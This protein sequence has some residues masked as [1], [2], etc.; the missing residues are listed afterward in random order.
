MTH[1]FSDSTIKSL[2]GESIGDYRKLLKPYHPDWA[3]AKANKVVVIEYENSSRGL[4]NHVAKYLKLASEQPDVYIRVL[5][6]RSLHHQEVHNRDFILAEFLAKLRTDN[7]CFD[8]YNC[9]G[10]VEN[11]INLRS[12]AKVD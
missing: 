2:L 10:T 12:A 5:L 7:V 11:L 1:H 9:N 8:F 4:V 3:E 6:I